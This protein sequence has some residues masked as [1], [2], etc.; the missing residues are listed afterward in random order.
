MKI[1]TEY[2]RIR[3]VV[4]DLDPEQCGLDLSAQIALCDEVQHVGAVEV[5]QTAYLYGWKNGYEA[6]Q[7][8]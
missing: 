6:A 2:E 3:E 5:V 1:I 4:K 8:V 7:H